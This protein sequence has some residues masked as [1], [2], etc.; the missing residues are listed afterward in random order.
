VRLESANPAVEPLVLKA[1]EVV[2][3]GVVTGVIR[4]F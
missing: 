1:G 4:V 2:I 3:Q